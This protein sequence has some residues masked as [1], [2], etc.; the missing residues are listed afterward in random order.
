MGKV[1]IALCKVARLQLQ[2]SLRHYIPCL[3]G[4]ELLS[5][6]DWL[7]HSITEMDREYVD[8]LVL[9]APIVE[10]F[11]MSCV[12][13]SKRCIRTVRT[14]FSVSAQHVT[15]RSDN[16]SSIFLHEYNFNSF[17]EVFLQ[18]AM[19][20]WIWRFDVAEVYELFQGLA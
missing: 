20:V 1:F 4:C 11:Q 8:I 15:L 2:Q 10:T 19:L 5:C 6:C 7:H 9:L 14:R 13:T 18:P 16:F 17:A 12:D 3:K